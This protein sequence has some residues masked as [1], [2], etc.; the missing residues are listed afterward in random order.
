[1]VRVHCTPVSTLDP[2]VLCPIRFNWETVRS[3]RCRLI[4][5]DGVCVDF[6]FRKNIHQQIAPEFKIAFCSLG[7]HGQNYACTPHALVQASKKRMFGVRENLAIH[8]ELYENQCQFRTRIGFEKFRA[9]YIVSLAKTYDYHQAVDA[10]L[11]EAHAKKKERLLNDA[12]RFRKGWLRKDYRKYGDYKLKPD[13]ILAR[14][15]QLRT[16]G[17]ISGLSAFESGALAGPHKEA[18]T[19]PFIYRSCVFVYIPGPRA[20]SMDQAIDVLISVKTKYKLAMIIFS[21]DSC[22]SYK[23][24]QG[25]ILFINCDIKACDASMFWPVLNMVEK[26][27]CSG[28]PAVSVYIRSAM[29]Q[30]K[31]PIRLINRCNPKKEYLEISYN[32]NHCGL[33]SGHGFTTYANNMAQVFGFIS[34]VDSISRRRISVDRAP[35]V[36]E[37][38]WFRAGFQAKI[39]EGICRDFRDLQFL[40]HS[41]VFVDGAYKPWVN[42]S[43]WFKK[44]GY[45]D[46]KSFIPD[47]KGVSIEE[48]GRAFLGEIVYSR[49]EWGT[50]CVSQAFEHV[51]PKRQGFS[52]DS[53]R[54]RAQTYW[55]KRRGSVN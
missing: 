3:Y 31:K 15:K 32:E 51:F 11:N 14:K 49:R 27:M 54:E 2:V 6:S 35:E 25:E 16:I 13:E 29:K 48:K 9:H 1:V 38:A 12:K 46:G 23:D 45:M 37:R 5:V 26:V 10:W 7:T 20:D 17:E 4:K 52:C 21:D 39:K 55:D 24:G 43:C 36:F 41:W 33:L 30:L 22:I 28:D 50:H 42:L 18:F 47:L 40:K 44:F 34:M 53:H 19:H 8:T